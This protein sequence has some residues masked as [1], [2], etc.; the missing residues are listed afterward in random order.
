DTIL[1][2][3]GDNRL[4]PPGASFRHIVGFGPI[5]LADR[6][7]ARAI[8]EPRMLELYVRARPLIE[9]IVRFDVIPGT[10]G[11]VLRMTETPVGLY[12]VVS[13]LTQPMIMARNERSLTRLGDALA[14]RAKPR[15]TT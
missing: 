3:L 4:T 1:W 8:E 5:K 6:T 10:E 15:G 14:M 13:P 12:K 7:T 9:A 11:C 2:Y